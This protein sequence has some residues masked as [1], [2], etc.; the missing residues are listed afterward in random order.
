MKKRL[1]IIVPN[2]WSHVMGGSPYESKV[3]IETLNKLN[4]YEIFYLTKQIGSDYIPEGYQLKSIKGGKTR[5]YGEFSNAFSL[6]KLLK[7]IKPDIIYQLVAGANTGVASYYCKHN[8][9]N[10]V[11]RIQHDHDVSPPGWKFSK[12]PLFSYIDNRILD[13]GIRNATYI[14]AQSQLQMDLMEKYY[15]RRAD[16]IIPNFHPAPPEDILKE[17]PIKV[18]WVANLKEWKRPEIFVRLAN[19]LQH[20]KG[21]EFQM[22]GK[23]SMQNYQE[24]KSR[25]DV[26]DNL[27]HYGECTQDEV[28]QLLA[29]AH[30]FVN[31]SMHEGFPH[32]YMQ[33]WMRKVPVVS[34]EINPDGIFD[35]GLLGYYADGDYEKMKAYVVQLVEENNL[36]K[37]IGDS[38]QKYAFD[39][40]SAESQVDR[41][42][43]IFEK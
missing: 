3:L 39:H 2:H 35:S 34:L 26:L 6:L 10:M 43:E 32:T 20:L 31:T 12:I 27:T 40:F 24:L 29:K 14:V 38:A 41:L 8:K 30:I 18:A 23:P 22:C 21:V 5:R 15:G 9:C 36:R 13:Y 1:C 19:D 16:I 37:N 25:I 17:K 7:E 33:S 28:N 42:M 4:R 11:W